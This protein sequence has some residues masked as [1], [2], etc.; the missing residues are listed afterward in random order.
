MKKENE[1]K[2]LEKALMD[3]AIGFTTQE[4]VE[5]YGFSGDDFVLQKRKTSTKSYPPDLS[6]IQMLLEEKGE[7]NELYN[8]T[9]EE[10]EKEK[11]KLLSKLKEKK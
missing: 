10:L 7:E 6:A 5:E 9:D 11:Q 3:K 4:V 1:R 2:K 8:L